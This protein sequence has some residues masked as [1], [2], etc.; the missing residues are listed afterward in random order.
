MGGKLSALLGGN[1][2]IHTGEAPMSTESV[3]RSCGATE[4]LVTYE[5]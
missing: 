2:L 5:N 3:R 1:A 4:A